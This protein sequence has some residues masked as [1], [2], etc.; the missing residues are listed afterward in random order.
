MGKKIEGI[1]VAELRN[2]KR[3]GHIRSQVERVCADAGN[4]T[5]KIGACAAGK[6]SGASGDGELNLR[7]IHGCNRKD[8]DHCQIVDPQQSHS[9]ASFSNR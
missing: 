3:T 6:L 7:W 9:R 1:E 4:V 2:R 5:E 8:S